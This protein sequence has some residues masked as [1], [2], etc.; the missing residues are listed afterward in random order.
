MNK[1][2]M[3][4][5]A[6]LRRQRSVFSGKLRRRLCKARSRWRL[7]NVKKKSPISLQKRRL[8]SIGQLQIDI[9]T[10][11]RA[12]YWSRSMMARRG[13]FGF[14]DIGRGDCRG[15][16]ARYNRRGIDGIGVRTRRL[17]LKETRHFPRETACPHAGPNDL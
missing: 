14:F 6:M 10:L 8:T 15:L 9:S 13:F 2:C 16:L 1:C 3:E 5:R 12:K 7:S 17:P 4:R 11:R